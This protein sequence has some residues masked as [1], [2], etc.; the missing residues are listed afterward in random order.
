MYELTTVSKVR[1]CNGRLESY[2]KHTIV[3]KQ[4]ERYNS[5]PTIIEGNTHI[6]TMSA[7]YMSKEENVVLYQR[8]NISKCKQNSTYQS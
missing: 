3:L 2:Q 4:R 6:S 7:I 8:K 5:R 1:R